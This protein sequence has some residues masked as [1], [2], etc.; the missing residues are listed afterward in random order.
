MSPC[1]LPV[2]SPIQRVLPHIRSHNTEVVTTIPHTTICSP[3]ML[4]LLISESTLPPSLI[5]RALGV[6]F[7]K[8]WGVGD[9]FQP[10]P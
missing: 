3:E 10:A 1:K 2:H 7:G 9:H 6:K 8:W 5:V 4:L